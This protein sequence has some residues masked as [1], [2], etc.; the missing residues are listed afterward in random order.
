MRGNL[1]ANNGFLG[2]AMDIDLT[3]A[4]GN[5]GPTPNDGNDADSG[6]NDLQNFPIVKGLQ[7]PGGTASPG[8]TNVAVTIN[9][10]LN[11]SMPGNNYH[12][13]AYFANACNALTRRGTAQT[14]L[15]NTLIVLPQTSNSVAFSMNA[16][17]PNVQSGSVVSLTATNDIDGSTSEIGTC[18]AVDTIYRDGYD[19]N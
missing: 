8:A 15:T 11:S 18:I 19:L 2:S 13:D 12:V 5:T 16:T 9:G 3:D 10:L 14:Y 17:L 1:T 4:I 7:Y 6:A